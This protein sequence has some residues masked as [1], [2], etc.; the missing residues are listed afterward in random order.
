MAPPQ[1]ESTA[2][3]EWRRGWRVVLGA[4]MAGGF[5]I[6]LFYYVFSL[7][8]LGMSKE[9]GVSRG[10]MANVQALIVVGALFAPLVGRLLDRRG[11]AWVFGISTLGVIAAHLLMATSVSSIYGFAAIAFVYGA[12]GIGC[13]GLSAIYTAVW[14]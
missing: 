11:F 2:A 4:A 6:P 14:H 3:G 12:F 5:G 13:A 8:L 1:T 7:F 9:F 10:E